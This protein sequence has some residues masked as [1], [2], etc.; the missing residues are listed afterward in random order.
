MASDANILQSYSDV[1]VKEDVL[2]LIE[3][4]TAQESS[5]HNLLG[6]T[7][8][9]QTVH[10]TLVDTLDSVASRALAEQADYSSTA[11]TTPS[12]LTNI[13]QIVYK[14]FLVSN[15]QREIE[16]YHGTDELAR[17]TTKAMK[18]WLNSAEYDLVRGSLVSG[19]SGTAPR[20][21]GVIN[22]ISKSTNCTSHTSS[23]VFS[24]SVLRGLMKANWD[25]CNGDVATDI[26]VSSYLANEMDSFSNKTNVTSTGA[27]V[28]QIINVVEIFETGLGRVRRH[29]HRYVWISAD[30][31]GRILGINPDKLKVAYL[32]KPY[33]DTGIARSGDY[34][35]RA[36]LGKLTLEVRN[37]DSNFFAN[38]LRD[39]T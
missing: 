2:G 7:K 18:D 27:N 1:S 8:A 4:L 6:K 28:K 20:M 14:E 35:P 38:G 16:H 34:E 24:A 5:V 13:V 32:R 36:V 23:V 29:T 30:T 37:Q 15:T 19:V 12:R 31:T 33:I 10:E 17:Q 3:I 22:A 26:F 39:G 9:I 11:L 25:N 21:A